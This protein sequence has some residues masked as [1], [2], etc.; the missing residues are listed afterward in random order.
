[1][2]FCAGPV[3]ASARWAGTFPGLGAAFQGALLQIRRGPGITRNLAAGYD[4]GVEMPGNWR[5]SSSRCHTNAVNRNERGV[6]NEKHRVTIL[7]TADLHMN[8]LP[9]NPR[10]RRSAVR[11][12]AENIRAE[13]GEQAAG[14]AHRMDAAIADGKRMLIATHTCPWRELNGHPLRGGASDILSA[15]SGNSLVGKEIENRANYVEFLMCGHTHM[16]VRERSLHGIT[17]LN[18]GAD[19]GRFRGIIYDT[20][21]GQISWVGEP[22]PDAA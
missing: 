5:V 2:P 14:L 12:I 19:Y 1:M 7:F 13:A 21:S 17:R 3:V 6:F 8:T 15:Y 16:P 22:V 9:R 4:S 10:S 18:G 20:D 11:D